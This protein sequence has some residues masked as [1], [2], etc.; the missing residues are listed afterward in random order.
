MIDV[1][2]ATLRDS[3]E[4]IA[5]PADA[6]LQWQLGRWVQAQGG[7]VLADL[8]GPVWVAGGAASV[9]SSRTPL[10]PAAQNLVQVESVEGWPLEE[11]RGQERIAVR[12]V[13]AQQQ[14]NVGMETYSV[15]TLGVGNQL[16]LYPATVQP[17]IPDPNQPPASRFSYISVQSAVGSEVPLWLVVL[18]NTE[19]NLLNNT[20]FDLRMPPFRCVYYDSG[21]FVDPFLTV[22]P[23]GTNEPAFVPPFAGSPPPAYL[24]PTDPL[25]TLSGPFRVLSII[26]NLSNPKE[27][28]PL[29]VRFFA[30]QGT[31]W[32]L[33]AYALMPVIQYNRD[34][35]VQATFVLN[36]EF[37]SGGDGSIGGW[38]VVSEPTQF[39]KV[40][41]IARNVVPSNVTLSMR[42][43]VRITATGVHDLSLG[44]RS[45]VTIGFFAIQFFARQVSTR[46][47][48]STT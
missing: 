47:P 6:Q 33:T 22:P 48:L 27:T 39:V 13:A 31:E 10:N 14:I 12:S 16:R 11:V 18:A 35:E 23:G 37:L 24:W 32:E 45:D 41:E 43:T 30:A 19:T 42:T 44:F 21:V 26:P 3:I 28:I 36:G 7:L 4:G 15:I 46:R 25:F 29:F 34:K 20:L 2:P 9:A 40:L 17:P 1:L 5:V 38:D 8:L